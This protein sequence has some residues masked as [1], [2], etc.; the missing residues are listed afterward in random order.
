MVLPF[1]MGFNAGSKNNDEF[2]MA[3]MVMTDDDE[4]IVPGDLKD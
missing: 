2:F 3:L 4:S 1:E